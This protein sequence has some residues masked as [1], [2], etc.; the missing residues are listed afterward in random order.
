MKLKKI[1]QM[2]LKNLSKYL[3]SLT[4]LLILTNVS[5]SEDQV[6][7]W[8]K[9]KIDET[10]PKNLNTP[11]EEKKEILSQNIIKKIESEERIIISENDQKVKNNI[12]LYGIYDPDKNDLNLNMWANSDGEE[13]RRTI[14]RI[15]KIKLSSEIEELFTNIILTYSYSPK[16]NMTEEEFLKIKIDWLIDNKKDDLL[17][18]FLN[19]N[20]NFKY[21]KKIIQYLVDKNISKANLKEGCNKSE[22]ISK[23]IKDPYLE[24][25]KIYCLVFNNKKNEAQLVHDILKEQGKSD[26]FFDNKINFLLGINDKADKKIKDNNLLNFYLSSVTVPNFSYE[27][28]DKTNKFIWEYLN[29]ANL[30][31]I[32]NF[33]DKGKIK[34]LEVAANKNTVNK[35]KIFDIYKQIPFDLNTLINADGVYQSLDG[36]DSRALIYQKFLLSDN[37]ENKIKLLLLLKD[38]FKKDNLSNVYTKFMSDKLKELMTNDIPEN[39]ANVVEKNI[40]DEEEYKL[41]KIKYDDKILHKSR[42]VRYYTEDDTPIQKTQ[43]DLIAVYKRIKKNKNYFFSAK[44]L[45]LIESLK[46]DGLII[47]K[48]I[49]IKEI[50]S[51]YS[52]PQNLLDLATKQ[53]NGLLA[54]K[55]IEI[56]GEDEISNLDPETIYF[57]VNILNKAKLFKFRN[58]VLNAALP[59][60]V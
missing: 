44:D 39:F 5:Q 4:L 20:K 3:F 48:E 34:I 15:S 9:K 36:I 58:K 10:A 49:D 30:V 31:K 6:D 52:V 18:T 21:K 32:Q 7:I 27:P 13:I 47:S 14:Q 42:V 53:E 41:G 25:F 38:L 19:K 33:E 28:N 43:K 46:E 23:E 56:I 29:S 26:T 60:R 22:F 11:E 55:F 12:Q 50:S 35:S 45:A 54:L 37:V 24:K 2:K 1:L 59:L 57:I 51:K 17:E 8:N 16:N 40:I